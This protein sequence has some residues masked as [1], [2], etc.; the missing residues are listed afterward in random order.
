MSY[1]KVIVA[2]VVCVSLIGLAGSGA[3]ALTGSGDSPGGV[4]DTAPPEFSGLGV[5]PPEASDGETVT[6]TF[7]AS[8]TL[9]IDPTVTVNGNDAVFVSESKA[10]NYTYEYAVQQTDPLGPAV[11]DIVGRD[12]MGN[13]G[14]GGDPALLE[15]VQPTPLHAWPLALVLLMAALGTLFARRA[16]C[17]AVRVLL[18]ALLLGLATSTAVAQ[19]PTVSNVAFTQGP[20]GADG[21]QVEITYD[22]ADPFGPCDIT[23]WLSKD[24]G[25]D[26]F[27]HPVT[28]VTGD[29]GTDITPGPGKLIVWDIAADY[30]GEDIPLAQVRVVAE[31]PVLFADDFEDGNYDGWTAYGSGFT[32]SV[33]AETAANGTTH[34]FKFVGGYEA[35]DLVPNDGMWTMINDINGQPSHVS[36]YVRSGSATQ[37]DGYFLLFEDSMPEDLQV[38]WFHTRSTGMFYINDQFYTTCA[39]S[40]ETWY[41]IEFDMD[42]SAQTLD[43]YVNSS[44]V[45]ADIP[46]RNQGVI[47]EISWVMLTNYDQTATAWWDEIVMTP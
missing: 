13:A 47:S 2:G 5:D 32:S 9:V 31:D 12:A 29:V 11:I 39:Y 18:L 37:S 19:G 6:I 4:L 8:E 41:H 22:L 16:R 23:V 7:A 38:V 43:F 17:R 35:K 44:L 20:D 34:S 15:I 27:V 1:S 45:R 14:S 30:P 40:P 33:T 24:A 26:G 3:F 10:G 21:T 28:S 46:F 25:A 42:W 36:F